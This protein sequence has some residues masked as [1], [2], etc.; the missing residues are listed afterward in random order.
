M[1][2]LPF[3]VEFVLSFPSHIIVTKTITNII[4]HH[5]VWI[6]LETDI[7]IVKVLVSCSNLF[8]Y[9]QMRLRKTS[10]RTLTL[11]WTP[12]KPRRQPSPFNRSSGSS[13][14]RRMMKSRSCQRTTLSVRPPSGQHGLMLHVIESILYGLKGG[15]GEIKVVIC[16]SLIWPVILLL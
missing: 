15:G 12:L 14:R 13:R 9:A 10:P 7:V 6:Y 11:T 3:D 1:F 2:F 4:V 8:L 5:S 16:Q